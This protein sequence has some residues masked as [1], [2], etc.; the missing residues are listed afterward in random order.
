MVEGGGAL[1]ASLLLAD[2]VDR[3]AMFGAGVALGAEGWPALG[4]MGLGALSEAPRLR[5]SRVEQLGGDVLSLWEK[6]LRDEA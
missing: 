3:L 2:V 5:L 6:D 1:A 4:A